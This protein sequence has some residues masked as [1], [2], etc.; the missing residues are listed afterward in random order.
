MSE[1]GGQRLTVAGV[2]V[3]TWG[4]GLSGTQTAAALVVVWVL[5][6][7][8]TLTARHGKQQCGGQTT[9]CVRLVNGKQRLQ[10]F[11]ERVDGC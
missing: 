11:W 9:S 4:W 10:V 2:F 6:C 5:V 8:H 1:A 3:C 7:V